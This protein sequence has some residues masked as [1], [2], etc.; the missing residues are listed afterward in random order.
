MDL[1]KAWMAF[2]GWGGGGKGE[3]EDIGVD[4]SELKEGWIDCR[5]WWENWKGGDIGVDGSGLK[6]VW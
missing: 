4:R 6:E 2:G 1:G 5:G 3:G